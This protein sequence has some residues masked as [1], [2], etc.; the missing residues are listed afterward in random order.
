LV[1]P[2]F[3]RALY[4][5]SDEELNAET[6]TKLA[7]DME[8]KILGLDASPRPLMAIPHLL[9]DE[10]SCAYQGYLL[11]HMAVY[12]TRAYLT[13]KLGFLTDNP[14]IGPLLAK[15]YWNGGNS[16][17]HNDTIV[18]LTGEGFNAKYLADECNLSSE[19]AWE[20]EQKKISALES[21]TRA[22]IAPLN[23]TINIIDGA[24]KLANNA[25]S[26]NDMCNEFEQFIV[27]TYGR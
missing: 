12:Q 24:N 5:L 18:N 14:E 20:I 15:Y 4:Q 2:Y 26:D 25:H 17:N 19:Q 3:E 9:S 22:E 11:A 21:R 13:E 16:V 1:V 23:A 10:A 6:V 7:R 27:S 8:K